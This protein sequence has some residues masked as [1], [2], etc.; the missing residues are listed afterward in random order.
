LGSK[1][2]FRVPVLTVHRVRSGL[3]LVAPSFPRILDEALQTSVACWD[4]GVLTIT[5]P[6]LHFVL[7]QSHRSFILD[8]FG[9]PH[10][11]ITISDPTLLW[12][13]KATLSG[14]A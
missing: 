5:I 4:N 2:C 3:Y 10:A 13:L 6:D 7:G 14:R 8:N 9:D 1:T 12:R 11:G